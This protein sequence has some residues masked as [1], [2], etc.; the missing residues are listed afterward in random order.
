MAD[1]GYAWRQPY[2]QL[3]NAFD[4]WTHRRIERDVLYLCVHQFLIDTEIVLSKAIEQ[5]RCDHLGAK[6]AHIEHAR[7]LGLPNREWD[8][9]K[10]LA[11]FGGRPHR[12]PHALPFSTDES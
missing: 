4:D 10:H 1:A 2:M 11:L 8:R 3:A 12:I 6:A 5:D 7:D 9:V